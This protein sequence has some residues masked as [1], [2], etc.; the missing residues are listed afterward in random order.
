VPGTSSTRLALIVAAVGAVSLAV[1]ALVLVPWDPIPGG[2]LE[3]PPA[4]DY[5][6]AAEIARA[7][8]F[9]RWARVW[10]WSS[11]AVSVA[12]ACVL[13][14]TRAG[15]ALVARLP[16]PWVVQVVLAVAA[17]ALIGRVLTLPFAVLLRRRALEYGL[18]TQ[19]WSGFAADVAKTEAIGIVVT[20]G[21]VIV[22][23][24]CARR[25]SR[26]WP[27]VAGAVLGVLVLLGSFAYPLLVEPLFNDFKSLPDGPLRTEIME[28]ADREGVEVDDVL[29]ADASRRTT[30]LNAYV[31]GIGSS[32]RVVVYDTLID[33][34]T[35]EQALSVIA[36][37]LSHARHRD[38]MTASLLGVAGVVL[39]AGLLGLLYGRASWRHAGMRDPRAVP[40]VLALAAVVAVLV[41]PVESTVSR[42]IETRADVDAL[43]ATGDPATFIEM[44]LELARR[45]LAD[46]TPPTWSHFWLASHPTSLKRIALAERFP[47]SDSESRPPARANLH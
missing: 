33:E 2:P 45:S 40:R 41:S 10:G 1:L 16:G 39:G 30:T 38:V 24:G 34:L 36:H 47:E 37:E 21:A 14:F 29:V 32:R 20:S 23:I 35:E 5:F 9:S 19:S 42:R 26:A 27:A 11:L 15:E 7:E 46:P 6:T 43:R 13:G 12:V 25:W 8:E 31:S 18:S 28:L 4:S 17:L 3:A 22:V 44:Q